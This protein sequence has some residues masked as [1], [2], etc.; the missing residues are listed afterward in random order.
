M[1]LWDTSDVII[2]DETVFP[3]GFPDVG[4]KTFRWVYEN[5]KV[6]ADF[7]LKMIRP[8]GF[9]AKWYEYCQSKI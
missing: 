2:A 1:D 4:G 5:R 6:W 7:T 9:F 8:T 3:P